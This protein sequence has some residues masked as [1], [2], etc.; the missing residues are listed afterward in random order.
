M[1]NEELAGRKARLRRR[2]AVGGWEDE[3]ELHG[4]K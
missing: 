3:K 2:K 1:I 4:H